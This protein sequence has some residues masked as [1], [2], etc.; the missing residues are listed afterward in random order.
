MDLNRFYFATSIFLLFLYVD[1][2]NKYKRI[3]KLILFILL[4]Y[5]SISIHP[6]SILFVFIYLCIYFF[7]MK[8]IYS[9]W[10]PILMLFLG[11]FSNTIISLIFKLSFLNN[12]RFF[13]LAE[14]YVLGE[15]KWADG[16]LNAF[17]YMQRFTEVIP[18]FIIYYL[19]I[20]L[21]KIDT[22]KNNNIIKFC[23]ILIGIV[24]FFLSYKSLYERYSL[25]ALLFGSFIIYKSLI[26]FKEIS[27]YQNVL[28]I[29]LGFRF[30]LINVF[31]YGIIFTNEYSVILKN[32]QKKDEMTLKPFY[33]L[34]PIL[35]NIKQNGYSDIHIQQEST[36]GKKYLNGYTLN[37]AIKV[38]K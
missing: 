26:T 29:M 7:K 34:T 14:S 5:I 13:N 12:F 6:S 24:L 28:L 1:D 20:K 2:L 9:Y 11:I 32:S 33:Y 37:P 19:G 27:L 17:D 25:A 15:S 4:S 36:R 10:Y 3:S 18:I 21:L 23:L 22:F 38:I 31:M 8:F 16:S 35:F 30:I